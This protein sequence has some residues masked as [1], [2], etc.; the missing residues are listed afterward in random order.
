MNDP[1]VK[2]TAKEQPL[3]IPGQWNIAYQYAAGK[4]ATRFFLALRDN[5]RIYGTQCS[6]CNRIL[7]PPRSFCDRC[8]VKT[9]GWLEVGPEGYV[10]TF[11]ISQRRSP[12]IDREPPYMVALIR[13]DGASTNLIHFVEGCDFT[14]PEQLLKRV[15]AGLRVRAKFLPLSQRKGHIFDIQ[16]FVAL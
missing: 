5:E 10:V 14:D 3:T 11:A 15:R 9:D 13:L 12:G 1:D 2:L 7:V 8:F 16:S 6:S 4:T